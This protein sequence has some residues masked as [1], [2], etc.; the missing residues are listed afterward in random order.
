MHLRRSGMSYRSASC[1]GA[2]FRRALLASGTLGV[3]AM[4]LAAYRMR[5]AHAARRDELESMRGELNLARAQIERANAIIRFSTAYGVNAAV[6]TSV[7]DASLREGIDPDL[8]FRLVR[9]ESDFDAR[10]VS[11]T[12]AVGLM[13]IMPGTAKLFERVSRDELL[14]PPTN[15]RVG[16]RYLRTLLDRYDGDVRLALLAYNRGEDAVGRDLRAGVNPGNGYD[17]FVMRGYTG[18]GLIQ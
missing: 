1:R 6:A 15:L 12:G 3:T 13:Q 2:R 9:L 14:D 16:F 7:L 17:R 4:A 10:A 18:P 11:K 8:A 5:P